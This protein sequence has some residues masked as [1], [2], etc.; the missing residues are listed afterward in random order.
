MSLLGEYFETQRQLKRARTEQAAAEELLS[1]RKADVLRHQQH[2]EGVVKRLIELAT[3]AGGTTVVR[4]EGR[5]YAV[6]TKPQNQY[7]Y[8][9]QFAG[10]HE[11]EECP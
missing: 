3:K 7:P 9:P 5:I 10:V 6:T 2:H 1:E 11:I 4:F 8:H